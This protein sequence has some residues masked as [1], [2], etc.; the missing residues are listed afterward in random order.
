MARL[1]RPVN[2]L[3]VDDEPAIRKLL[4]QI[5]ASQ[6]HEVRAAED[7]FA[8][9]TLIR[10]TP[11]DILLSDLNMPGMTGFELLS[12]VR[13][14][15]PEIHVIAT[16]GAYSG[17]NVPH[18]IAADAFYEKATGLSILFELLAAGAL[19]DRQTFSAA[20][21]STPIWVDLAGEVDSPTLFVLI[22]CPFCLRA[23]RMALYEANT[24]IRE[25]GCVYCANEIEYAIALSVDPRS[26]K[27][28]Q[29]LRPPEPSR[30]SSVE[31]SA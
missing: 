17:I 26:S 14:L 28:P 5:F 13:R 18:G 2:L 8:A 6:G 24:M 4:T 15:Y 10:E 7:G 20:R 1:A 19:P 21:T 11:P 3:I 27:S 12:I 23:F 30:H 16:S 25:T 31:S 9:L 22:S 29:P